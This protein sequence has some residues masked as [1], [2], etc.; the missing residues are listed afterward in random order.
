MPSIRRNFRMTNSATTGEHIPPH[1]YWTKNLTIGHALIDTDHRRIFDIANQLQA[2]FVEQP[3]HS[4]VGE[5]LVELIEHTGDHFMREEALMQA[6]RYPGVEEHRLE[7]ATMMHQVNELHR[8]FMERKA[9]ISV[10]VSEFLHEGLVP[11]ILNTDM[12]L[13]RYLRSIR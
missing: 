4:I 9:N 5:A 2:E 7:H 11:H 12:E 6:V 8:R 3:E 10:E 13:G 1:L